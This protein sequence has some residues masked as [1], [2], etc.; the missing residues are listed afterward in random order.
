MSDLLLGFSSQVDIGSLS[1]PPV[2]PSTLTP[3]PGRLGLVAGRFV[4]D[5]PA[6]NLNLTLTLIL[7]V[8]NVPVREIWLA[9]NMGWS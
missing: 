1:T 7:D 3:S 5:F 6:T 2:S 4:A 8:Y 9:G